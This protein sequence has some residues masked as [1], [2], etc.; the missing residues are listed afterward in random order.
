MAHSILFVGTNSGTSRHRAL[1]LERLGHTVTLIEPRPFL[2][3]NRIADYWIFHTGA[4]LCDAAITRG[5]LSS[6]PRKEFDLV[7]VESGDLISRSLVKELKNR[8]GKVVNYCIDDPY[9]GRDGSKWRHYLAALPLYDLVVVMRE[10]NVEEAYRAGARDVL[11]VYMTADEVAHAP[12]VVSRQDY[13]KW[14][15]DV[16]FIGTWMPERGPFLTQLIKAGVRLSIFGDRWHKAKEW[17][18]L[19]PAWRGPGIYNDDDYAMAIQCAKVCIGLLSKGNRDETTTRSFEIPLL[20]SVLCAER[21]PEHL[22]LYREN[23]EAVFWSSAEE[24]AEKCKQ[25]LSDD[26]WRQRLASS[27]RARCIRNATTNE[28]ALERIVARLNQTHAPLNGAR[29]A[30]AAITD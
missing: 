28:A 25:L 14:A 9:G 23:L 15:S 12:R 30:V 10:C 20:G 7:W 11:R 6:I 19:K 21:T 5:V 13:L 29:L 3:K 24:C 4:L 18:A 22:Q 2:P 1:A 16:V 8:F 26:G 17:H 27:G